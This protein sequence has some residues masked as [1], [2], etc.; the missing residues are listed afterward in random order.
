MKKQNKTHKTLKLDCN[1]TLGKFDLSLS[2]WPKFSRQQSSLCGERRRKK[3]GKWILIT[4]LSAFVWNLRGQHIPIT[5]ENRAKCDGAGF[6]SLSCS[7][8]YTEIV[9]PGHNDFC[10]K[11]KKEGD[12]LNCMVAEGEEG[13]GRGRHGER[14]QEGVWGGARG[15][16]DSLGKRS[17]V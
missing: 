2:K 4:A 5:A 1:W 6:I 7:R 16:A 3:K 13:V 11:K 12:Y 9:G 14:R 10:A 8:S 17:R 15:A